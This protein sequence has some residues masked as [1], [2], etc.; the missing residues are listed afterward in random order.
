[1]VKGPVQPTI[2]YRFDGT[3]AGTRLTRRVDLEPE[4]FFK[5]MTP[6]M[7]SM[8]KRGNA[9]FVANLKRVL[10]SSSD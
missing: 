5:L 7:K 3:D 2:S 1:M 8:M 9:R 10:E 4:G 6:M